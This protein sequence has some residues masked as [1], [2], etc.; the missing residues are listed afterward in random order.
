VVW[1][2]GVTVLQPLSEPAGEH[3]YAENNTYW[4]RELRWGALIAV[5]LVLLIY[6]RGDRRITRGVLL[7]GL[8]WLAA[9]IGLDRMDPASG[10]VVLAV[11]AAG[12][13][14]LG[15]VAAGAVR[16][17]PRPQ[18]LLTVATVAAVTSGMTTGTESPTDVEHALNLGSAAVGSLLAL[19]AVVAAVSAAGSAGRLRAAVAAPIGVLAA[20]VPC[21]LRYRYPQPTGDRSLGTLLFTVVLLL[22]IVVLAGPRPRSG[23][24]WRR[25]PA[26]LAVVAVTLPVMTVPLLYAFIALP[27]GGL[28]TT[29]AGN[30]PVDSADSD[31]V[32]DIV[33]IL[34]GLALGRALRNL[35]PAR[36]APLRAAQRADPAVRAKPLPTPADLGREAPG[37]G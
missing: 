22:T 3:A 30:P 18:V 25:Y 32:F 26:A 16:A 28:F 12:A 11:A 33:A 9:D 34:I 15:C 7:G 19:V 24:D 20:A 1:A 2:L 29:L 5:V 8:T 23:R 35:A 21:L 10:T 6:A 37:L 17:V 14:I 4:A 27:V 36:P 13:A 31:V